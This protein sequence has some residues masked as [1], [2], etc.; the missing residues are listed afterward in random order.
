MALVRKRV[1]LFQR[2]DQD[3]Q[4]ESL[5]QAKVVPGQVAQLDKTNQPSWF[6]YVFDREFE[7]HVKGFNS[8]AKRLHQLRFS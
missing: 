2:I 7:K 4:S 5:V 6:D 3:V 1:E 8:L